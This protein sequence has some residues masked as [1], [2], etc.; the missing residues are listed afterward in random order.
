MNT[1]TIESWCKPV[2][3]N[4]SVPM[5]QISFRVSDEYRLKME[6]MEERFAESSSERQG[7]I[8][9]RMADLELTTPPECGALSDAQF[10]VYVHKSEGRGHF[11][12][13]GHRATDDALV[14]S[15]AVM[16]DE[17]G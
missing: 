11:F 14:Y 17:L 5:G 3:A 4:K 6:S 9:V 15:N 10:H 12:L 7:D 8:S 1:F 13:K 16:V 2:G